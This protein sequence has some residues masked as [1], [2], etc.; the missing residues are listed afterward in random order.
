MNI[1]EKLV[2]SALFLMPALAQAEAKIPRIADEDDL[3]YP[4]AILEHPTDEGELGL[5]ERLKLTSIKAEGHRVIYATENG[6]KIKIYYLREKSAAKAAE[7]GMYALL[8]GYWLDVSECKK[9]FVLERHPM[10]QMPGCSAEQVEISYECGLFD[11]VFSDSLFVI[12]ARD[13]GAKAWLEKFRVV[14]DTDL[15]II[16]RPRCSIEGPGLH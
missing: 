6:R 13:T 12:R 16:E 1:V 15:T 10:P 3:K 9:T 11:K 5:I 14:E 7:A 4:H 2:I 8:N